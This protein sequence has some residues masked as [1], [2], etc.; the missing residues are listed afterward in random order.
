M[1]H[2][3]PRGGFTEAPQLT[4]RLKES[5]ERTAKEEVSEINLAPMQWDACS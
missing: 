5:V 2:A 4:Y 1:W 3:D